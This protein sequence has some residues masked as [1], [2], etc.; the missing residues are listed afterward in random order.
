MREREPRRVQELPPERGVA[1]RR[2]PGRRRPGRSIAARWTRIW[3]IR[4]VSSR[5]PQQRVL[6]EQLARPRSA[7]PPRAACRCRA[8]S[9]SGRRGRGRSAPRSGP[10]RERGPPADEREVRALERARRGR[11]RRAACAPPRSAR[12]PSAP[13]CP[14]RAGGRSPGARARRRATMPASASTSVPVARPGARVDDEAGRLVDDGEVLVLARRSRGAAVGGGGGARLARR[15]RAR[16][17]RRP[18]A[19]SSSAARAPSTSAPRL[20]RPLGRRARAEVRRRGSGRAAPPPPRPG[21][22]LE[23]SARGDVERPPRPASARGR[24]RAA[25]RAGSRRRS[26]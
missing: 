4:P 24:R 22:Q 5:D 8:R 17:A 16:P 25:P 10:L 26:R 21:R 2:R 23:P 19:G 3:C 18:R 13:T 7:S 15:G 14:G 9:G 6:A 12:R 20:D 1:A 11:A